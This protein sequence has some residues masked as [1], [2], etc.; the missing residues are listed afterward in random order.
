MS[1]ASFKPTVWE[2]ALITAFRGISVAEVITT[3]PSEIEGDTARFNVV[4]GGS[5]KDYTGSV[6]YDETTTT[7]IDLKFNKQKYWALKLGDVDKIQAAG[8]VLRQNANDKALDIKEA[9]DTDVLTSI[10]NVAT[11]EN[12]QLITRTISTPEQA[13]DAIV[14]L[15]TILDKN[16][17]PNFNR[18]ICASAEFINLMSKDKRFVDNF[19]VLPNGM[20]QGVS[21]GGFT[22]LKTEDGP[23]S[24]VIATYKGAYG[25]AKQL[26]ETEALR[27][28]GSFSDA[29]RGL[30]NYGHVAIRPKGIAVLEYTLSLGAAT[31]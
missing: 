18:Y 13:Y 4:S 17:V 11:A 12:K 26:D 15:G 16:K 1:I 28:E 20:L 8:D 25:F 27:L 3:P 30:I 5:V 24:K 21:V 19:N 9:I 29:M 2:T 10:A 7:P 23:A 22:I 6:N 14:D 31:E